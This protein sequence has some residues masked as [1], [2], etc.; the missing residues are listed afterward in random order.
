MLAD[1][2]HQC[3][4]LSMIAKTYSI[5]PLGFSGSVIEI[6]GEKSRGLP[7]FN[8][9]GMANKT[10]SEARER[11]KAAIKSAGFSFPDDKITLNLAPAD[12]EKEGSYLDLPIALNILILSGQLR[13]E[14]LAD[15]AFVGE[16][17]LTGEVRPV[18][19][20]INI[21]ETARDAGFKQLF[22]PVKNFTQASLIKNINLIGVHSLSELFAHLKN[23]KL[24]TNPPNVVKNTETDDSAVSFAQIRG[25][26][27]PKRALAIAIAGHHNIL[28]SGPPGTGKTMLAKAALSL[29]PPLNQSEQITVTKLHNISSISGE[30]V[31]SRPFRTPH[32]SA[33]LVSLI[34]GGAKAEPGEISLAHLGAL[35]LDEL[36]EFPRHTIETLRQPLEDRQITV[37]RAKVRVTYPAD[38]MLIAT[39]NPCPCGYLNDPSHLCSCSNT[40][41][42]KYQHK[43]S[44]PLLDRIDLFTTVDR[45]KISNLLQS[46]PPKIPSQDLLTSPSKDNLRTAANIPPKQPDYRAAVKRAIAAQLQRY[47]D[48]TTSNASL[49]SPNIVK[50]IPLS[51][52][53]KAFLDQAAEKLNLSARSYFKTIKVA[54]T[55]AD[56]D[57][58][59]QVEQPHIAEALSFRYQPPINLF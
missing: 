28:L 58:S 18:S 53:V 14:D 3:Y 27:T 40:Q 34:G 44:G 37:T 52:A 26:E 10:V 2:L 21:V 4:P 15:V 38:F 25:Q 35:F 9:V 29:L 1:L 33:S 50:Y 41:I 12:Q 36:P 42:Q 56:L 17:S 6:E 59:D 32:H 24:I 30:I 57:G 22:I 31:S 51:Q 8:I 11:V 55:I 49:S 46:P 7:G 45:V 47:Q 43:L 16:L 23:Q 20:I 19:S 48:D 54:R 13:Q 5:I 39:M